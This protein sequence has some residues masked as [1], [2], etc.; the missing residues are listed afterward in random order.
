[1]KTRTCTINSRLTV[2]R[3]PLTSDQWT[4]TK[5]TSSLFQIMR[6]TK[7]WLM[8]SDFYRLLSS[9]S[10]MQRKEWISIL[11]MRGGWILILRIIM[12][13]RMAPYIR[14][15]NIIIHKWSAAI[16]IKVVKIQT[17]NQCLD[18]SKMTASLNNLS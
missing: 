14:K 9:R 18:N 16:Q 3:T 8:R 12:K 15:I 17:H 11:Q 13:T 7:L 5:I 4:L 10:K 2:K 6:T 1:M